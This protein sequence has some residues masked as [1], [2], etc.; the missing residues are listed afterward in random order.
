MSFSD[1]ARGVN[2]SK[3]TCH[4]LLLSLSDAGYVIRLADSRAYVLGPALIGVARAAEQSFPL[5][6]A[7]RDVLVDLVASTG[8]ACAVT[9]VVGDSIVFVD[10]EGE[11]TGADYLRRGSQVP[12]VAPMGVLHVA[13]S[14][15]A[16]LER[17]LT[18]DEGSSGVPRAEL[19]SLLT[20]VRARGYTVT[21][22]DAAR[23]QLRHLLALV[24]QDALSDELHSLID[25]SRGPVARD[26]LLAEMTGR[27]VP[28][29]TVASP[30]FAE[31]GRVAFV[32]HLQVL[33]DAV[34]PTTV[35]RLAA[36]V[37]NAAQRATRRIASLSVTAG[38]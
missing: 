18:S 28:V 25:R 17:W 11:P 35:K 33:E 34:A 4:A 21:P 36:A 38:A 7:V 6:P 31:P 1:I 15:P 16:R 23:E 20:E 12:L 3:A 32:M 9:T 24:K 14:S 8:K 19:E 29:N 2:I 13:W 37:A 22:R 26:Y 27:R 10:Y 5:V 30:V